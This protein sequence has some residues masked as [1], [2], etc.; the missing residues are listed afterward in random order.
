MAYFQKARN[1]ELSTIQHLETNLN[2]D[3]SNITVVKGFKSAY[4]IALPVVAITESGVDSIR[5]EVGNTT[6]RKQFII[7][8]DIFAKSNAMRIDLADYVSNKLELGW[9]YYEYGHASGDKSTLTRTAN[10]R[11]TFINFVTNRKVDLGI[12]A[13]QYDRYRH[14]ITFLCEKF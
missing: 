1:V 7:D 8:I 11:V 3:W 2:A 14:V 13:E 4:D 5:K 6:H 10:G 9:V 12:G